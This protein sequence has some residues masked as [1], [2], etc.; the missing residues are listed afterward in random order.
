[1][2]SRRQKGKSYTHKG[3]E[4]GEEEGKEEG[5]TVL[6]GQKRERFTIG[7]KAGWYTC[8]ADVQVCLPTSC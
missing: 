4:E 7:D 6:G 5:D 1:M 8:C 2:A 3:E